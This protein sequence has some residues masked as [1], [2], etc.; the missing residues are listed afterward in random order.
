MRQIA[1]Q[2]ENIHF[3]QIT[4]LPCK[5]L[6]TIVGQLWCNMGKEWF[7][8]SGLPDPRI[9]PTVRW[10]L[11]CFWLYGKEDFRMVQ[12]YR[13]RWSAGDRMT[14]TYTRRPDKGLRSAH[15]V[16][17]P[18]GLVKAALRC[19]CLQ[20]ISRIRKDRDEGVRKWD[21]SLLLGFFYWKYVSDRT[22]T[23]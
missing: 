2:S 14:R 13:R 9:F 22:P 1:G 8:S 20:Q 12:Q 6:G 18:A 5:V 7:S 21:F 19:F 11:V 17:L 10:W 23:D 4:P 15:V 3:L 16:A